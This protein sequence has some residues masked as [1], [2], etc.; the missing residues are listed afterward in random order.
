MGMSLE[1]ERNGLTGLQRR[2][3]DGDGEP[4]KD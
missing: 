1:E 4:C 3:H 2:H